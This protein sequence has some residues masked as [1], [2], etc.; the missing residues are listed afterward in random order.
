M[1]TYILNQDG[2]EGFFAIMR[3]MGWKSDPPPPVSFK[4]RLRVH[5]LWKDSSLVGNMYNVSLNSNVNSLT[6]GTF[7]DTS[8]EDVKED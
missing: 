3:Q 4:H 7:T 8:V 1:L 6:E 2:L 5:L